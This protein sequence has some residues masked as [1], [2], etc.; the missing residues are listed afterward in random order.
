MAPLVVTHGC[1]AVDAGGLGVC[2]DLHALPRHKGLYM[3][4]PSCLS[5]LQVQ[6]CWSL[7]V[8]LPPG[9][10]CDLCLQEVR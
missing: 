3:Y 9:E 10:W 4:S 7:T 8:G 1:G 2:L 5:H 6:L